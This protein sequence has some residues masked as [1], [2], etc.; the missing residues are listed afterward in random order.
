MAIVVILT[1][2]GILTWRYFSQP[3]AAEQPGEENSDDA[4]TADEERVV[5]ER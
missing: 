3:G 1:T 5:V 2:G 4:A